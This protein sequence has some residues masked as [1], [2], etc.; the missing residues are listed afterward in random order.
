M[1]QASSPERGM[2]AQLSAPNPAGK[3]AHAGAM[4]PTCD[5]AA[6]RARSL[7]FAAMSEAEIEELLRGARLVE[8]P[9]RRAVFHAGEAG[10]SL[11]VLLSGK[12]K[13]SLLSARARRRS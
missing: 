13:V 5:L 7:V 6:L 10:D 12:V 2:D 4:A 8:V 11:Y 9:A 3:G 1:T